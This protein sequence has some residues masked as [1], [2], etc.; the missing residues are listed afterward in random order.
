MHTTPVKCQGTQQSLGTVTSYKGQQQQ[1]QKSLLLV[2]SPTSYHRVRSKSNA[3]GF[4]ITSPR[5][6]NE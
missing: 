4:L 1:Q 6:T 2:R 3:K 5:G